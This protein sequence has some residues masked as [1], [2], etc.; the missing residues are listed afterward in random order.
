MWFLD[1]AHQIRPKSAKKTQTT[2]LLLIGVIGIEVI[3]IYP[4]SQNV[5]SPTVLLMDL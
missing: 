2:N 5:C 3:S 4:I 1:L